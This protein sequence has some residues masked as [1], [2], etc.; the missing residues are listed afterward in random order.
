M[1]KK[2]DSA[3]LHVTEDK[4]CKAKEIRKPLSS[5]LEQKSRKLSSSQAFPWP[6]LPHQGKEEKLVFWHQETSTLEFWFQLLLKTLNKLPILFEFL[7]FFSSW[8]KNLSNE[9][10]WLDDFK[11]TPEALKFHDYFPGT[12]ANDRPL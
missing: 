12:L 2:A 3:G 4:W 8:K 7:L 9:K 6:Q 5:H 1:G 10:I 11:K